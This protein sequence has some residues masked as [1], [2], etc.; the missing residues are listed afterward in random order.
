MKNIFRV[1]VMEEDDEPL[2]GE[3]Y[4]GRGRTSQ[5]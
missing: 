1:R 3:S 2:Y 4:G 5:W